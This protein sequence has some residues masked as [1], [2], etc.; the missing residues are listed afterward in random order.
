MMIGRCDVMCYISSTNVVGLCLLGLC[1]HI[2]GFTHEV[3]HTPQDIPLLLTL[4]D[5]TE[6][7]VHMGRLCATQNNDS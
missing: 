7:E 5:K 4:Q 2:A 6:K 3:N 1:E